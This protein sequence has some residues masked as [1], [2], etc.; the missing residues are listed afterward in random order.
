M[1]VYSQMKIL[2]KKTDG[3]I[4]RKKQTKKKTTKKH[5]IQIQRQFPWLLHDNKWCYRLATNTKIELSKQYSPEQT[6][7]AK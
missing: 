3:K 5:L 6:Y 1:F 2:K 7:Y 4:Y